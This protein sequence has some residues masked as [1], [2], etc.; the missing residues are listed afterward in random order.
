M[1]VFAGL[2]LRELFYHVGVS[3]FQGKRAIATRHLLEFF[4]T[5]KGRGKKNTEKHFG[6]TESVSFL[7]K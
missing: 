7:L 6:V 2:N 3:V 1:P 5:L 4:P